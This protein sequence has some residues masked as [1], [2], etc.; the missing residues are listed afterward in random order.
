MEREA[1]ADLANADKLKNQ[2]SA[3]SEA[4]NTT[5]STLRDPLPKYRQGVAFLES[6]NY[7]SAITA[8]SDAIA[9][10]PDF[11]TVYLNR[12]RAY[13]SLEMAEAAE[14]DIRTFGS[15]R[16]R[17]Q[18]RG[19]VDF[20]IS[21]GCDPTA[22]D[23][24]ERELRDRGGGPTT[25]PQH[26]RAIEVDHL[27]IVCA[28]GA[29]R[30]I[31]LRHS[32]EGSLDVDDDDPL[33]PVY[34]AVFTVKPEYPFSF[35]RRQFSIEPSGTTWVGND[36]GLGI[37]DRL[38]GDTSAKLPT[39]AIFEMTLPN[40]FTMSHAW[41]P[42]TPDPVGR[43]FPPVNW[44]T[45]SIDVCRSLYS[46]ATHL[47][48]NPVWLPTNDAKKETAASRSAPASDERA[49]SMDDITYRLRDLVGSLVVTVGSLGVGD[50]AVF[51]AIRGWTWPGHP[52]GWLIIGGIVALLVGVSAAN[53]LTKALHVGVDCCTE[54]AGH[55]R[56]KWITTSKS[57]PSG[58]RQPCFIWIEEPPFEVSREIHDWLDEGDYVVVACW[59]GTKEVARVDMVKRSED[60]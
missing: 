48:A 24:K 9:V 32:I 17:Q 21:T 52:L 59:S 29:V 53:H 31:E 54:L 34:N 35:D 44:E 50:A 46:I 18:I 1:Y 3:D 2:G 28:R 16:T 39:G 11:S 7:E 19:L 12:A 22:S 37:I 8:F 15:I 58:Q 27:R 45:L 33:K 51:W 25:D 47:T 5:S 36:M 40:T 4:L 56:R 60:N 57:D 42:G 55:V 6:A 49:G 38:N 20:L 41:S 43:D 10:D 13:Q 23:F 26:G 30:S 14:A